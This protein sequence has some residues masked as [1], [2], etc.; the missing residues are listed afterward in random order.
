[1]EKN[2][3]NISLKASRSLNFV[4][5]NC[6]YCT[7]EIKAIAFVSLVRPILEYASS[8]WDPY[9]VRDVNSLEMVQRRAARFV[10][11]DYR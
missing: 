6:Y 3:D 9:T 11:H 10:K 5:Q 7:P 8:A 1:M 4:R 2:V